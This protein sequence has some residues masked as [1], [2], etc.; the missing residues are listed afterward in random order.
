MKIKT[1]LQLAFIFLKKCEVAHQ[2][3][4]PEWISG[5]L[6][7]SN[8]SPTLPPPLGGTPS[9]DSNVETIA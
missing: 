7:H 4:N 6:P 1:N 8:P 2:N 3:Q 5:D 9:L